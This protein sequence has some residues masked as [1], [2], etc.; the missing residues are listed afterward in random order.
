MRFSLQNRQQSAPV[1]EDV[2]SMDGRQNSYSLDS[3]QQ[4]TRMMTFIDN[5][6]CYK[7]REGDAGEDRNGRRERGFIA[8]NGNQRRLQDSEST[9]NR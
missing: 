4:A 7:I 1:S 9:K 2:C 6:Q 5:L 8:I 3:G